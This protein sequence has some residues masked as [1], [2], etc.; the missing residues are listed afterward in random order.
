MGIDLVCGF[1]VQPVVGAAETQPLGRN[2]ADVVGRIALA[3]GAGVVD[4]HGLV[5][6][7]SHALV[8]VLVGGGRGRV[9]LLDILG[10]GEERHLHL[11][12]DRREIVLELVQQD[13][14]QV[15]N[16][17]A[18]VARLLGDPEPHGVALTQVHHSHG[19]GQEGV[20]VPFEDRFEFRL[21]LAARPPPQRWPAEGGR[22][23][24][25]PRSPGRPRG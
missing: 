11:V 6:Q 10:V 19:L 13:R 24:A 21:H 16:L 7:G 8:P 1:P 22:P 18:G 9:E 14:A 25:R 12:D 3:K 4:V 2:D 20:D 5:R 23:P 17:E 15:R